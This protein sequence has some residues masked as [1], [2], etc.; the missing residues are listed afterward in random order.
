M[1]TETA[2][3]TPAS[4][5][6]L[7]IAACAAIVL[8]VLAL[9]SPFEAGVAATLVLATSFVVGGIFGFV[10]G[11]R[12]RR[13][14]GTYGLMLLSAV[15][16]LAGLFI[17]ANPLIGLGTVTLVCIA[18]L[19]AS[20]I[21]KLFWSFKIPS[22]RGR[23]LIALSG[24]LSVIVAGML[25]WHFPFSAAWAFGVLVGVTLIF[26]GITHLAFLRHTA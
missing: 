26:E 22:G 7:Q 25:Y 17:F 21:T 5:L 24:L 10:A 13:W 23:G 4:K 20:G 8:G 14:A 2:T 11:L 9:I 15:S 6:P 1:N 12:A 19:A 3:L 16:I 18:G